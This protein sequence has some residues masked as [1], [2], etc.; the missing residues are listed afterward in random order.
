MVFRAIITTITIARNTIAN[1]SRCHQSVAQATSAFV[2]Y[3]FANSF[4]GQALYIRNRR[5]GRSRRHCAGRVS[6]AICAKRY[7]GYP[8]MEQLMQHVETR[9][10]GV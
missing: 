5:L 2:L 1:R 8:R 9:D 6:Y 7:C 4:S 10:P 3:F